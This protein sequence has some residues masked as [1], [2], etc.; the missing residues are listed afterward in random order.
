MN[1]LFKKVKFKTTYS[2]IY[3]LPFFHSPNNFY[4][5]YSNF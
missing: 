5:E 2:V 4:I 1:C 3:C